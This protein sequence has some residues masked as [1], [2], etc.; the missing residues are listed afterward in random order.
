MKAY[1]EYSFARP[2]PPSPKACY[3]LL[4]ICRWLTSNVDFRENSAWWSPWIPVPCFVYMAS[5]S[6]V[7][8]FCCPGIEVRACVSD[9]GDVQQGTHGDPWGSGTQGSLEGDDQGQEVSVPL[10]RGRRH[11]R[12]DIVTSAWE[13]SSCGLRSNVLCHVCMEITTAFTNWRFIVK[14]LID[15]LRSCASVTM[16]SKI[17]TML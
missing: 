1:R 16:K 8:C 17:Y 9:G 2:P 14:V 3:K 6:R 12:S 15:T 4:I 10:D 11:S 13:D 5:D 7:A